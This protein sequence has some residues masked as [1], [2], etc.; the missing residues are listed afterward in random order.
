[1]PHR[2]ALRKDVVDG[3][4]KKDNQG[5]PPDAGAGVFDNLGQQRQSEDVDGVI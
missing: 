1:M 5:K 4:G 3:V 2:I